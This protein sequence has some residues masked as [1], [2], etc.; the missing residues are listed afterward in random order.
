MTTTYTMRYT[1]IKTNGVIK[2]LPNDPYILFSYINT[3][4]RDFYPSLDE[5][6]KAEMCD[7]NTIT[8]K[9]AAAG[10]VYDCDTNRFVNKK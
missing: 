2:M 6:C 9:L 10:F 4:L 5:L 8:E 7:R 3:K 1:H